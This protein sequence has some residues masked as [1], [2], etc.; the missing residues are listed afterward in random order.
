MELLLVECCFLCNLGHFCGR[1]AEVKGFA[2]FPD[3]IPHPL[4][5]LCANVSRNSCHEAGKGLKLFSRG[6]SGPLE[7]EPVAKQRLGTSIA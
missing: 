5:V 4:I 2:G 7:Q 1:C 3:Q 6:P